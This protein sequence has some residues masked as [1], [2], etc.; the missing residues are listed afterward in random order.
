MT[1]QSEKKPK[2]EYRKGNPLSNAERKRRRYKKL[3]QEHK[4]V[5]FYISTQMKTYFIEKCNLEGVTQTEVIRKLIEFF[6]S[7]G[8]S[9]VDSLKKK[10]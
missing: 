2:R 3:I 10:C 1:E 7:D 9:I 8:Q 6:I 4:M 5:K